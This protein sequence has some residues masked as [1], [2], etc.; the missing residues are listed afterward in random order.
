MDQTRSLLLRWHAGDQDAMAELVRQDAGW[1][2]DKVR[3]RMGQLL[4]RRHDTQDIVQDTLLEVLKCGPRFVVSDR[5]QLRG[6]LATM[7]ENVLRGQADHDQAQKRDVRRE[8]QAPVE[9]RSVLYLDDVS[10][11]VTHPSDAAAGNETRAWVRLA[12]E[13]LEPEDRN[14]ILWREYQGLPFA[15]IGARMGIDT[16]AARMR[17]SRALPRLAKKLEMLKSGKLAAALPQRD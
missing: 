2:A 15:D 6:L 13:L 3:R 12:L 4:R 8:A 16:D 14:L 11:N 10:G 17:F 9:D 5:G 7:V 1:I